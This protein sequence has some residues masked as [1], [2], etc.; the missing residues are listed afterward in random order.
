MHDRAA[1][2]ERHGGIA[3]RQVGDRLELRVGNLVGLPTEPLPLRLRPGEA[4]P[5]AL[6]DPAALELR[7]SQEGVSGNSY[8]GDDEGKSPWFSHRYEC[9]AAEEHPLQWISV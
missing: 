9:W 8:E 2:A 1:D 6:D 5:H 4:G 7:D 3:R